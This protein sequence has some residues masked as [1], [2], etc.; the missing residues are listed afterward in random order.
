MSGWGRGDVDL[1]VAVAPANLERLRQALAELETEQVL[2]PALSASAL[3]RGH[4]CH[5]RSRAQGMHGLR[6]DVMSRMRGVDASN[7]LWRRRQEVDLPGIGPLAVISLPD[8]VQA[9]KTQRD[10]DWPMIRRVVEADIVRA[11]GTADP[12]RVAFWLRECRTF[13]MLRDLG[14][15]YPVLAARVAGRPDGAP[16]SGWQSGGTDAGRQRRSRARRS[17]SANATA[18]TGLRCARS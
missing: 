15:R 2:F 17:G 14:R 16:R 12:R 6:I 3:R 1:A 7:A 18:A 13:E 10:K 11:A 5:F 9:K 8:L 4:A